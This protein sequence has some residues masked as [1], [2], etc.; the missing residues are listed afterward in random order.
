[1]FFLIFLL[2]LLFALFLFC[3]SLT[4]TYLFHLT[5]KGNRKWSNNCQFHLPLKD[6]LS[7]FWGKDLKTRDPWITF[8]N[9]IAWQADYWRPDLLVWL[10]VTQSSF[11]CFL[12]LPWALWI[13]SWSSILQMCQ[14]SKCMCIQWPCPTQPMCL[15]STTVAAPHAL[16]AF[17]SMGLNLLYLGLQ[18]CG[19]AHLPPPWAGRALCCF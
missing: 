15:P 9:L 11:P 13:T 14:H 8:C 12:Q 18:S 6:A 4:H 2:L 3:C 16:K 5:C 19:K 17:S 1:M 7:L 10:T